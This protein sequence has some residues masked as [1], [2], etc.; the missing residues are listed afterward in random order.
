MLEHLAQSDPAY[1]VHEYLGG[2]FHPM[3]FSDVAAELAAAKLAFV[4]SCAPADASLEFRLPE[5]LAQFARRAPDVSLRETIC[6]LAANTSFRREVYRRGLAQST[7]AERRRWLDDLRLVPQGRALA[8]GDAVQ[9][10]LTTIHLD[11]QLRETVA[12]FLSQDGFTC[13]D[14]R[15]MPAFAQRSEH[16]FVRTVAWLL[17]TRHVAPGAPH[18]PD[19]GASDATA[20][21]NEVIVAGARDGRRP[22]VLASPALGATVSLDWLTALTLAEIWR[23]AELDAAALGR[24]V[25][26]LARA[27]GWPAFTGGGNVTEDEALAQA[28]AS[29]TALINALPEMD[30]R[31]GIV[32]P[33][34]RHR[35]QPP[36]TRRRS[37]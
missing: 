36:G 37:R 20:R 10:A 23:G 21:L 19:P 33:R 15:A 9:T 14:L 5:D 12:D 16:D 31:L 29:A 11:E 1:A 22:T 27:G 32:S 17:A 7:S 6:D 28:T 2:E 3:M 26:D 35:P 30:R 8:P 4:G 24:S 18:W 34:Q 25:S 13:G